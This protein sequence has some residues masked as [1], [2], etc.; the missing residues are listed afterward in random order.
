MPGPELTKL[1]IEMSIVDLKKKIADFSAVSCVSLCAV[2]VFL[3]VSSVQCPWMRGPQS[4]NKQTSALATLDNPGISIIR[5]LELSPY[6]AWGRLQ[7][8]VITVLARIF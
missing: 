6:S 1:L 5:S 3:E 7:Q 2:G 4:L 8:W